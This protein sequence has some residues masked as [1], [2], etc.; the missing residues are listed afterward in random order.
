MQ[1]IAKQ[2]TGFRFGQHQLHLVKVLAEIPHDG[3]TY[4]VVLVTTEAGQPY[5]AIR[6]YN[7]RGRFIKQLL[8]EPEVAPHVGVELRKATFG[9]GRLA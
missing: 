3:R 1:G 2:E 5:V 4:K 9:M 7:E 6:L 8:M